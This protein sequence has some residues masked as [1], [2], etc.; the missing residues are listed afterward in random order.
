MAKITIWSASSRSSF[1]KVSEIHQHVKHMAVPM[2][3]VGN[4][5]D[6]E[7]EGEVALEKERHWRE[8]WDAISLRR[9]QKT[10]RQDTFSKI[11]HVN[12]AEFGGMGKPRGIW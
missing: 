3:L 2:M 6:Q 10:G 12:C 7:G 11:L 4:K 1:I 5:C 9:Q 8:I